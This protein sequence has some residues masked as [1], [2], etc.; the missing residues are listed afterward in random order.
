MFDSIY[1][2]CLDCGEKIEAQTKSGPCM[3]DEFD[4]N[5]VP[6]DV[7]QDCNRHAPFKC[8]KCGAEYVFDYPEEGTVSL[9]VKR[10]F[11]SDLDYD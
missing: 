1:F 3:L 6:L 10:V 4:R 5:A 7:A 8:S 11:G 9:R 2:K